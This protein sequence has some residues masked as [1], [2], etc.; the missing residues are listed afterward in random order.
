MIKKAKYSGHYM[1]KSK[2][3]FTL[4]N[5]PKFKDFLNASEYT[6]AVEKWVTGMKE[7]ILQKVRK[8][9]K[10]LGADLAYYMDVR[11]ILGVDYA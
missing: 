1:P 7:Q 10:R 6:Y 2:F 8:D 3:P 5:F 9:K 4:E 11:D